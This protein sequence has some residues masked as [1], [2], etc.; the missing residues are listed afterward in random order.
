MVD[1]IVAAAEGISP[2]RG[3]GADENDILTNAKPTCAV[4]D[5]GF[6]QFELLNRL[7]SQALEL[8]ERGFSVGFYEDLIDPLIPS[9]PDN[10]DEEGHTTCSTLGEMLQG[11]IE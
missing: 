3:G 6:V 5:Y 8:L 2:M 7:R 9:F 4:D 11:F 1:D 10:S